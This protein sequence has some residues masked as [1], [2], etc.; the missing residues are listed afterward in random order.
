MET[1]RCGPA[2]LACASCLALC[3]I[4]C[5]AARGEVS[6]EASGGESV[7][8]ADGASPETGEAAESVGDLEPVTGAEPFPAEDEFLDF[9]DESEAD[10]R[11]P[12]EGLNRAVFGFNDALDRYLLE[13][14]ATGW[15]FVVPEPAQRGLDN[16]F[17]NLGLP[18]RIANDLLQGKPGKASNDFGRLLINTTFGLA[19]FFDVASDEGYENLE[20][21]FGQ[22]LGVWG[23]PSGPYVVLPLLGPSSPRDTAGLVVD[24]FALS[25]ER[26]FLPFYVN[27]S[28]T[29]GDLLNQRALAL[30]D[31]R[32]EREAAFDFYAAV[33]NA[34]TRFRANQVRDRAED[35]EEED[36]ED[37][38]YFED[39]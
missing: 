7:Q 13:P 19:G 31:V 2:G 34:Y 27:Y 22:T 30:E 8:P 25:P 38:Y 6:V 26:Y 1:V 15:D 17:E 29:G 37:L 5:P 24:N 28:W 11:D 14:I 12:W 4:L 32:A 23:V 35:P 16:F 10:D 33:R 3:L 20:E 36:D 9:G 39:E 18:R 21:D